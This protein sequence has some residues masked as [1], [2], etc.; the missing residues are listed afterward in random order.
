ML[1][2]EPDHT[3]V[4]EDEYLELSRS[5]RRLARDLVTGEAAADDLVQEAWL[6][7]LD[8]PPERVR[9]LNAW[10]R[11]V[12]RNLAARERRRADR[13][14]EIEQWTAAR[15]RV[16]S[17]VDGIA[18][19]STCELLREAVDSLP[20]PYR[21]V[22]RRRYLEER[23]VAEIADLDGCSVERVKS[24]VRR[25]TERLRRTL[26]TRCRGERSAWVALLLPEVLEST[27]GHVAPAGRQGA[28]ARAGASATRSVHRVLWL[29]V[30]SAIAVPLVVI[31]VD[32]TSTGD[33]ITAGAGTV[34]SANRP[35]APASHEP[36]DRDLLVSPEDPARSAFDDPD[37]PGEAASPVPPATAT[38]ELELVVRRPD[39]SFAEAAVAHVWGRDRER[40]G[41]FATDRG[42]RIRISVAESALVGPPQVPGPHGGVMVSACAVGGVWSDAYQLALP[43]DGRVFEVV[44]AARGQS[45][46]GT[47]RGE[48]GEPISN[49]WVRL[50]RQANGPFRTADGVPFSERTYSVR[51]AEDRTFTIAGL[52]RRLHRVQVGADGWRSCERTIQ[53]GEAWLALDVE[54]ARGARVAGRVTTADGSPVPD[55]RVWQVAMATIPQDGL[56]RTACDAQGRFELLGLDPA[57][58]RLFAASGDPPVLFATTV[59]E[60]EGDEVLDWSPVLAEAPVLAIRVE[61]ELGRPVSAASLALIALD[62]GP[63]WGVLRDTDGQ[64]RGRFVGVPPGPLAL[65][66]Q[67][68]SADTH[69]LVTLRD[70]EPSDEELVVVLPDGPPSEGRI[71]GALIDHGGVP[72]VPAVV[73]GSG[74]ARTFVVPVDAA[75][76]RFEVEAL[77]AARYTLWA[78]V[79]DVGAMDLGER[80]LAHAEDTDLGILQAPAPR[81]VELRW[82]GVLPTAEEPWLLEVDGTGLISARAVKRMTRP[83][84]RTDLLPGRY[85]L[86]AQGAAAPAVTFELRADADACVVRVP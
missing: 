13:R 33:P 86:R 24:Q 50:A 80:E 53:G 34:A 51:T 57:P 65:A 40:L 76:G 19:R 71:V 44:S 6:A 2:S 49:A 20:D 3:P 25:G 28:V 21:S 9:N 63:V 36:S 64:G 73:V 52:P 59:L 4:G 18:G 69:P 35:T 7:A 30:A 54:L 47:V 58:A 42:G 79:E 39:G 45:L 56:P 31:A 77:P 72:L 78:I 74:G 1:S 32:R 61:D 41:E 62:D 5:M 8:Q 26:D 60:P 68:G 22:I 29:V 81:S 66:V 67:R 15:E 70:L 14:L 48:G 12:L 46:H 23:T 16:E 38:R 27:P 17:H 83:D 37:L 10:M 55:A 84:L 75:T 82:E 85:A 43:P 11:Q